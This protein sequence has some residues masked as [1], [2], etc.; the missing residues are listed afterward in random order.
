MRE[1]TQNILIIQTAFIG[2]VILATSFIES[3]KKKYPNSSIH[4]LL[5]KGNESLLSNN[6]HV[7]Q[8]WIWDKKNGKHKNLFKLILKLRAYYFEHVFTIQRFFSMGLVTTL[9]RAKNKSGFDK[10]PFSF[11]FNRKV[12]HKIPHQV[13]KNEYFHEVQR[14]HQLLEESI[15]SAKEIRPNLYLDKTTIGSVKQYQEDDYVVMAPSSVWFTKQWSQEKWKG[16]AESL[17]SK[18]KVYLIGAPADSDFSEAIKQNNPEIVNLCG[19][20]N[21]LESAAL[22]RGAK[23]VIA[24]DSAPLHLASSMNAPSTAIFCSTTPAFGY[25]PL[26]EDSLV[27]EK[28]LD[29]KPCGLHGKKKCPLGHFKCSNDIDI[30]EVIRSVGHS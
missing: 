17:S 4:F 28:Q 16:L 25:Y 10:N 21:L 8:V 29:C 13:S 1:P 2:D 14:N 23:R 18:M 27:I 30:Q 26:S 3:V 15:P 24:N 6:P 9:L 12:V 19:K 7:D 5:R 11:F 20:L 22:M